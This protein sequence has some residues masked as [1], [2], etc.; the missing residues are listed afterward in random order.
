MR[1]TSDRHAGPPFGP[2]HLLAMVSAAA[3]AIRPTTSRFITADILPFSAMRRPPISP[4]SV[5]VR[6]A[7][8]RPLPTLSAAAATPAA[9]SSPA[10]PAVSDPAN[11]DRPISYRSL[12][13]RIRGVAPLVMHNGQL[14]DP[15]NRF[16]REMKKITGKRAKTEADYE[17]LARLEWLGSLYL[18]N[19]VPCIPGEMI[20]AG[21]IEAARK[22]KRG[23]AAKAA[24]LSDG[25]WLL[26]YGGPP[27]PEE[28]W[29][30]EAYRL[31]AGVRVQRNRVIR[32]RPIFRRWAA[33]VTIDYLPDMLNGQD[34]IETMSV[35]GRIIGL[36]DWRPRFGRFEVLS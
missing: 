18:A 1:L 27:T 20:E 36:G 7:A 9:S 10:T 33:Q 14:A 21:F 22:S 25:F 30:D 6:M 4:R 3:G 12:T 8:T 13:F 28:L 35:L 17:Q 32:T 15:L 26:D 31:S 2:R 11:S 23:Q 24:I 34:V 19:G 29:K 16:S 5:A